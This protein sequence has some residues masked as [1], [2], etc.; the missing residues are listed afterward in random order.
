LI[1]ELSEMS[2][3][4]DK[5]LD[6]AAQAYKKIRLEQ[7][8]EAVT[9]WEEHL[10]NSNYKTIEDKWKLFL[11]AE[12]QYSSVKELDLWSRE[13]RVRKETY[14]VSLAQSEYLKASNDIFSIQR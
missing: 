12:G 14:L 10:E 6:K 13:M 4:N 8:K 1:N 11:E 2:L 3:E 9:E 7:Y 5:E